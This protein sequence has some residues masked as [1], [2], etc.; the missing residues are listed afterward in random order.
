MKF[1]LT[2]FI[3][4]FI[5]SCGNKE[6]S[7]SGERNDEEQT[8]SASDTLLTPE[9]IFSTSLV[10]EIL[11]EEDEEL[12]VY[13]EEEF[14]SVASRSPKV[15]IDKISSSQYIFS[16]ESDSTMKNFLIQKFYIPGKDEFIFEKREIEINS[17]DKLLK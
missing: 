1:Y 15:T 4:L 10:Q 14:Y 5:Y 13:L 6:D 17:S 16:F 2:I 7:K 12:Q 3:V 11:D 9:E 8:E